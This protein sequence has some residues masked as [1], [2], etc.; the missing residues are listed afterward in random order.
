MDGPLC[1]SLAEYRNRIKQP[2]QQC[3]RNTEI[4]SNR[5]F[6]SK[7][8]EL[9]HQSQIENVQTVPSKG[10]FATIAKIQTLGVVPEFISADTWRV[11]KCFG[12][13]LTEASA[14]GT[15]QFMGNLRTL[16]WYP[17]NGFRVP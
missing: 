8:D 12:P 6:S 11:L 2:L 4:H 3:K 16:D 14:L 1:H 10:L 9:N 13:L 17:F 7:A 5:S 15:D